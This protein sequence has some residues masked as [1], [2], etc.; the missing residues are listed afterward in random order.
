LICSIFEEMA[1]FLTSQVFYI[2]YVM[3]QCRENLKNANVS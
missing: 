2:I 3:M 1:A